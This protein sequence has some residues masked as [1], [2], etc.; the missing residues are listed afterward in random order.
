MGWHLSSSDLFDRECPAMDE[1]HGENLA[2]GL[3]RL[4]ESHLREGF[5]DDGQRSFT[6]FDLSWLRPDGSIGSAYVDYDASH[7]AA[8]APRLRRWFLD[9]GSPNLIP[10]IAAA[11]LRLIERNRSDAVDVIL[12][13]AAVAADAPAFERAL[14]SGF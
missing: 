9:G 5:L 1:G 4:W 12:A 2:D 8:G 13:A 11:H 10:A 7:H 3:A 6:S 14:Q